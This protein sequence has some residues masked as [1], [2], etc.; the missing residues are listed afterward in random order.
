MT[1]RPSREKMLRFVSARGVQPSF[2][3]AFDIERQIPGPTLEW[4]YDLFAAEQETRQP[5]I[6]TP[7]KWHPDLRG[8]I[9]LGDGRVMDIDGV[10]P[11]DAV[12]YH[13]L[14]LPNGQT[15]LVL[16]APEKLHTP[17]RSFGWSIQ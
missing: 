6:A 8:R 17:S 3:D 14:H 13:A 4:L 16:A 1:S 10:L 15:Q 2:F 11:I 9:T 12:G 7:G 5:I